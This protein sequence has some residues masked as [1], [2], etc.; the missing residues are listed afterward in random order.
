MAQAPKQ[1]S[2]RDLLDQRSSLEQQIREQAQER[3]D[4][5]K[6]ELNEIADATGR[7]V[8]ELLGLSAKGGNRSSAPSG[9]K[10]SEDNPAYEAFKNEYA[11]KWVRNPANGNFYQIGG[12]RGQAAGWVKKNMDDIRAN[13]FDVLSDEEY[14]KSKPE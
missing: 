4:A 6:N 13:K 12:A 8:E 5:I 11:G 9:G 2:F 3:V 10:T 7:T 1:T 14:Q